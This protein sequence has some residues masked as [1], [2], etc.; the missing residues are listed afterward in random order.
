MT[1]TGKRKRGCYQL[2]EKDI[3]DDSGLGAP[4][5]KFIQVLPGPL[6]G[7]WGRYY[8]THP[9]REGGTQDALNEPLS[10]L[11]NTKVFLRCKTRIY[12]NRLCMAETGVL[13]ILS[14]PACL[15]PSQDPVGS[16]LPH[17]GSLV[18]L[19]HPPRCHQTSKQSVNEETYMKCGRWLI[20]YEALFLRSTQ[21]WFLEPM[22]GSSQSP[23]TPAQKIQEPAYICTHP[24]WNTH[25]HTIKINLFFLLRRNSH[26]IEEAENNTK[27]HLNDP[28]DDWHLHLI[29]VQKCEFVWSQ[30]PNLD[31]KHDEKDMGGTGEVFWNSGY[32][33]VPRGCCCGDDN[34][35]IGLRKGKK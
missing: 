27:S 21:I 23:I 25:I 16:Y 15:S 30:V 34:M 7:E 3:Q 13:L 11:M 2:R 22:L 28:Q 20:S 8:T 10:T 32:N 14:Q 4:W 18:A 9:F 35:R 24:H 1:W 19:P 29:G 5:P 12:F 31:K 6:G 17:K 26:V 33:T